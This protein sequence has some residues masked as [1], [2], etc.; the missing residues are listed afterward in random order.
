MTKKIF[1]VF[2]LFIHFSFGQTDSK[3]RGLIIDN[4]KTIEQAIVTNKNTQQ[5]RITNSLGKFV[6][7]ANFTDT[8]KISHKDYYL[9]KNYFNASITSKRITTR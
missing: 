1:L 6:T 2:I 7:E 5:N 4:K 9:K 3:I 8:L